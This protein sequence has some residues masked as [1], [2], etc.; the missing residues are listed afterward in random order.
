MYLL[1]TPLLFLPHSN[2]YMSEDQEHVWQA[3]SHSSTLAI[4]TQSGKV[5]EMLSINFKL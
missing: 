3:A 5:N 1:R 2:L 4:F